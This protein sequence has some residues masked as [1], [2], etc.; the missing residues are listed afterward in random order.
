MFPGKLCR[1]G[2]VRMSSDDTPDFFWNGRFYPICGHWFWDSEFGAK[3]FCQKLGYMNGNITK[4]RSS[5]KKYT[6]DSIRVGKCL[7]GEELESCSGGCNDKGIGKGCS[8]CVAG[9]RVGVT[10]ACEGNAEQLYR[11][12]TCEGN[13]NKIAGVRSQGIY[14]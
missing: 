12:I 2:D 1:N 10:I 13:H 5:E 9:E 8:D 6:E 14:D 11:T 4:E 7:E 3:T